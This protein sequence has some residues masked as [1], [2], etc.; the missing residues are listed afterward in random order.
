MKVFSF[1]KRIRTNH[2]DQHNSIDPTSES[3][4]S[5]LKQH[6]GSKF[7]YSTTAMESNWERSSVLQLEQKIEDSTKGEEMQRVLLGRRAGVPTV[8]LAAQ[9]RQPTP[10]W[11]DLGAVVAACGN[12][13]KVDSQ[14]KPS[15]F[16]SALVDSTL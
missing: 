6:D 9:S 16:N 10:R 1:I 15:S 3:V 14:R 5:K 12:D 8:I 7:D 2:K 4:I 11:F 13:D